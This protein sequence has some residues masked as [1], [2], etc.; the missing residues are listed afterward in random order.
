MKS[1]KQLFANNDECTDSDF[2]TQNVIAEND[3]EYVI[4]DENDD[5]SELITSSVNSMH[6]VN[7]H[8][9]A[10]SS[11]P[12]DCVPNESVPVDCKLPLARQ[13]LEQNDADAFDDLFCD[14]PGEEQIVSSTVE[15]IIFSP[16]GTKKA[17]KIVDED[18]EMTY[19]VDTNA[20]IPI[21]AGF[22]TKINDMLSGNIPFQSNV[23]NFE[24]FC[25]K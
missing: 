16:G 1:A 14:T 6:A 18:C 25:I 10:S 5:Q 3:L 7:E 23:S 21:P 22:Q 8:A 15:K 24:H 19:P 20:F 12:N 9:N 4:S 17:T 2:T 13:V 11:S